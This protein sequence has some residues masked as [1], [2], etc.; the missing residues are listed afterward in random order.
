MTDRRRKAI[1]LSLIILSLLSLS[2]SACQ[3]PLQGRPTALPTVEPSASITPT[4]SQTPTELPTATLTSTPTPTSTSTLVPTATSTST[5]TPIPT[6]LATLFPLTAGGQQTVDWEYFYVTRRD[7][8]DDGSLRNLSAMVSFQLVDR[9]IHSETVEILGQKVTVYY[10]RVR[11]SFDQTNLEVKLVLTG[12]FGEDI[13]ISGIPADGS[14]YISVRTQTASQV[15]EPW[16]LHQDWSLP[17]D[18]RAPLF[19]TVRLPDFENTLRNLPDQVI[20]LADHP[21]I[22]DPDGWAQIYLDMDR[23]SASAARFMPFFNFNEYDQMT[24]QSTQASVWQ[25]YLINST[26]IP[27]S[28]HNRMYFSADFLVIITP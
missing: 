27:S 25:N 28:Q 19:Q 5:P 24:G 8:R 23:V 13:P 22:L 20:V 9:G 2:L 17:I 1:A 16:K 10:L 14:S 21:V 26:D 6:R 3:K 7:N 18:Q 11:H 15:F 12:I 4:P